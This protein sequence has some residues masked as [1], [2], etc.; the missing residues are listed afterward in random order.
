MD[1]P[2]P[3]RLATRDSIFRRSPVSLAGFTLIELLVV[4]AIIAVLIA[5]LLPAVQQAREAARRS[6]CKNNLKQIGLAMH[7]YHD[8]HGVFT[9]AYV[10]AP[11]NSLD[12]GGTGWGWGT[13]IL[14]FMDQAPL[15]NKL[16]PSGLMDARDSNLVVLLRTVISGYLCPSNPNSNPSQ[17][18]QS[19]A[20]V[21][22]NPDGGSGTAVSIGS[23]NYVVCAGGNADPYRDRAPS[24]GLPYYDPKGIFFQNSRIRMRDVTDGTSNTFMA[25]ERDT[26]LRPAISGGR[27]AFTTMGAVW[28]GTS[29]P[30]TGSGR[31]DV[32]YTDFKVAGTFDPKFPINGSATKGDLRTL[33]SQHVGGIQALM[34]DGS[35]RFVNENTNFTLLQYLGQRD[36]G[37][38]IG[39]W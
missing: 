33:S 12:D 35:V 1:Y 36:D 37:Q 7:N 19:N 32:S 23:S 25:L 2:P 31:V 16:N 3:S 24:G 29:A 11:T 34:A 8:T 38:T 22:I 6:Q 21:F 15:Y 28:A 30:V 9:F 18:T 13:M 17:N 27:N 39:D 20:R 5:L 14:P 4:I 26:A 10:G